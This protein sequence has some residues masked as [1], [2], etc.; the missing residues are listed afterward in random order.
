MV[1]LNG[2]FVSAV[3]VVFILKRA[4]CGTS[5]AS[6]FRNC[7]INTTINDQSQLD[8]FMAD[9]SYSS[10]RMCIQLLLIG[11]RF[12]LDPLQLMGMKLDA[13]SSL[14]I[15]GDLVNIHCTSNITDQEELM[16]MLQP[17]SRAQSVL[18]DGLVFTKCPVPIVIEEVYNVMIQNCVFL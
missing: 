15:I 5:P 10:G 3:I 17:I 11:D 2:L 4:P 14:V 9:V 18:F 6:D 12:K 16:G 7:P 13:N 1:K 8:Q